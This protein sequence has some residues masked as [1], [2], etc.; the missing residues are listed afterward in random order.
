[1]MNYGGM[2][3]EWIVLCIVA[4]AA[5]IALVVWAIMRAGNRSGPRE[6]RVILRGDALETLERRFA[7]GE[8]DDQEYARRRALLLQH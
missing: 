5:I 6:D 3:T 1:M 8:I 7:S 4:V 2:H